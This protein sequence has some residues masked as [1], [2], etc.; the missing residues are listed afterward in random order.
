MAAAAHFGLFWPESAVSACFG[1]HFGRNWQYQHVLVAVSALSVPVSAGIGPFWHESARFGVNKKKK[2]KKGRVG[3]SD[4]GTA[5]LE[6]RRCFLVQDIPP[7]NLLECD[8]H[9]YL[10]P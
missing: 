8:Q 6:L 9:G 10:K 5:T 1:G 2:K 7:R 3:A 4:S